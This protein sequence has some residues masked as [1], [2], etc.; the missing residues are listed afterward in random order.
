MTYIFEWMEYFTRSQRNTSKD[1]AMA[2]Q[3]FTLAWVFLCQ[4][5]WNVQLIIV[6]VKSF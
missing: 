4:L 6:L 3:D 2:M 5:F 1:D